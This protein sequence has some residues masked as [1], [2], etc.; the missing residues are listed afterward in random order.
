MTTTGTPSTTPDV[1]FIH[2]SVTRAAGRRSSASSKTSWAG[3]FGAEADRQGYR[4]PY[5]R[6]RRVGRVLLELQRQD[7]EGRPGDRH[8]RTRAGEPGDRR[9]VG[10]GHRPRWP[11]SG[12]T[13]PGWASVVAQAGDGGEESSAAQDHPEEGA[14]L[15]PGLEH[16]H[17]GG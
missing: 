2:P 9:V 1:S 12:P 5:L 6:R 17:R 13:G 3:V 7:A 10:A 15:K 4:R 8:R 14:E 11:R 16:G